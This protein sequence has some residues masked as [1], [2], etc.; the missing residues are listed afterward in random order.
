MGN[1]CSCYEGDEG[2]ASYG[3]NNMAKR[4]GSTAAIMKKRSAQQ[5]NDMCDK[6]NRQG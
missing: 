1:V 2:E 5:F 6:L 4:H 3:I